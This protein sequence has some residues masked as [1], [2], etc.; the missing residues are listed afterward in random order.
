VA[1]RWGAER[2]FAGRRSASGVGFWIG[3]QHH[4]AR[5]GDSVGDRV[6]DA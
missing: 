2:A 5:E 3:H 1:L 4:H 6:V